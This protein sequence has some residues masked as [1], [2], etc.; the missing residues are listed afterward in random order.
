MTKAIAL[1]HGFS[2]IVD[3]DVFEELNQ[4]RWAASG[5]G[6]GRLY[7]VRRTRVPGGKLRY[8]R[9]HRAICGDTVGIDVDHINGNSLDNRRSNLRAAT[10]SQNIANHAGPSQSA[11]GFWGVYRSQ[12]HPAGWKANI[13]INNKKLHLGYFADLEEAARV[14]DRAALEAWGEFATLNFPDEVAS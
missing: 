14:R 3:D 2:A 6:T 1:T 7:A 5:N 9:M 4:H 12:R 13:R 8:I 10:R 11:S